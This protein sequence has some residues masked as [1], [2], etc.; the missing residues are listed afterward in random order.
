MANNNIDKYSL[1]VNDN[2]LNDCFLSKQE[3]KEISD[4]ISKTVYDEIKRQFN[5]M[6]GEH[7]ELPNIKVGD[8]LTCDKII[9]GVTELKL[10]KICFKCA[11]NVDTQTLYSSKDNM[12]VLENEIPLLRYAT[13][14]QCNIYI[15][16]LTK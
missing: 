1:T 3:I 5:I 2:I 10:D 13:P 14:E 12:I 8:I 7:V 4:K 9:L 16:S 11:Y 6:K 15:E